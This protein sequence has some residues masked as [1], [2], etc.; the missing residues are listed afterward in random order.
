MGQA[1]GPKSSSF[2]PAP[3]CS[4]LNEGQK[5]HALR[6]RRR[7]AERIGRTNEFSSSFILSAKVT[8]SNRVSSFFVTTF[9]AFVDKRNAQDD[10]IWILEAKSIGRYYRRTRWRGIWGNLVSYVC[11]IW[12][13]NL[14]ESRRKG[15]KTKPQ[16]KAMDPRGD[17]VQM[18]SVYQMR[19][20]F[21][22]IMWFAVNSRLIS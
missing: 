15:W 5:Q 4:A 10:D 20:R 17:C 21:T 19:P 2:S 7:A 14:I 3:V 1:N 18:I 22:G 9:Y 8:S 16:A 6:Y 13:S 12:L 11:L